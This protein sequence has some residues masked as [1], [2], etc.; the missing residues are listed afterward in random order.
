MTG[1]TFAD[2]DFKRDTGYWNQYYKKISCLTKPSRFAR[3][4]RMN[5]LC[6]GASLLELGCGNGRDSLY[7]AEQGLKVTAVDASDY[8][9]NELAQRN[10]PNA[11]FICEDFV[12][13]SLIYSR[14]YDFC[15]SRFSLHAINAAQEDLLLFNVKNS[16]KSGGK[17]FIEVRSVNDPLF[18]KGTPVTD[19]C[20][21]GM[22]KNCFIYDKHFR[23]F[24]DKKELE[25]TL[26]AKG[27]K[28][29]YS[30]E[31]TGFAPFGAE[32]PPVIRVVAYT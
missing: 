19:V 17:F 22:L 15:Y 10:I 6:E 14:Q 20:G 21:G 9:I 13:S 16:L 5:Y 32:D 23:R 11:E 31:Q 4:V 12:Q 30:E 25:E 7:F 8:A 2:S 24:I 3:F 18:G 29:E 1:K 27:Y 26:L 28:I